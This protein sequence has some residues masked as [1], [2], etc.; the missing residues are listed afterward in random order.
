[1]R[2]NFKNTDEYIETFPKPVQKILQKVRSTIKKT[3]PKETTEAISYQIPTF[4]YHGNLIHFAGYQKHI[5]IYPGAAAMKFFAPKLKAY[6]TS[7]GAVQFPLDE[8]IPYD[9]IKKMTLFCIQQN[10]KSPKKK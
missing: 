6:K 2:S 1:M 10:K 3:T 9:L 8:A 4:K 5:G 7:K